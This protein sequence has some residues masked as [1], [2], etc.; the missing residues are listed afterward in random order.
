VAEWWQALRS[1]L[2][3]CERTAYFFAGAQGPLPLGV[4]AAM[5][6]AIAAWDETGWRIRQRMWE[7]L[8]RCRD[9]IAGMVGCSPAR[10]VACDSTSDAMSLAAAM[11][12]QRRRAAGTEGAN[13][14]LHDE[15]HASGSYPWHNAVRLGEPVELRWPVPDDGEDAVEAI[16]AAVDAATI[17]VSVAHISHRTGRRLDVAALSDRLRGRDLAV[18]VDAA[19]SAGALGLEAEVAAADFV[20]FPANKWL[21]GP[22]G[23]GFL[24]IAEPWLADP[25]PTSVGWGSC[26]SPPPDARAFEL[27]VGADAFRL[28]TPNQL[29]LAGAAAALQLRSG[30]G[31][32]RVAARI[33]ELTERFLAG[34]DR[35]GL[36]SPTPRAWPGRA[37]VISL[38]LRDPEAVRARL[39]RRGFDTGVSA[40]VLR[41]D[42][43]AY[44]EESEVDR[45]L[46]ELRSLR[47]L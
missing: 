39:A 13:V 40:G 29:G 5:D 42:I 45:L 44:N 3:L 20:G 14:V 12:L 36:P 27:A 23:V 46:A 18:I 38:A 41:V 25:G 24:V 43:H 37:G 15:V 35:Q 10:V 28:G 33:E 31:E 26:P 9:L 2:P 32:G 16:V 34:V 19:Q 4:R 11:V 7:D 1:Q 8:D 17:A 6:D 30:L 22:P 47:P 21:L